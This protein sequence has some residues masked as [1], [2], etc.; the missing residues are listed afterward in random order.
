MGVTCFI[1]FPPMLRA[2][3]RARLATSALGRQHAVPFVQRCSM[4]LKYS[5]EHEW[6]KVEGEIATVGI[7]DHAQDQL[8]D[9]VFVELP[10]V[11]T[12]A[13]DVYSPLS[14]EITEVN[15]KLTDEPSLINSSA[16]DEGWLAKIKMS[17]VSELDSLMDKAGYDK[18][19]EES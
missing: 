10:T 5:K 18:F 15:E 19:C 13:S 2:L 17:T 4:S 12:A 1:S 8:G 3:S 14:G 11:G 9:V 6:V 16:E 7:T